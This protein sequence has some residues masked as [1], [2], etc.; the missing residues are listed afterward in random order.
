MDVGQR[1]QRV[2][3]AVRTSRDVDV[4]WHAENVPKQK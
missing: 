2:A 3:F 1:V 4:G